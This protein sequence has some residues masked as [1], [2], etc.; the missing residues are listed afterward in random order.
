[1][2]KR[3]AL[4]FP[5]LFMLAACDPLAQIAA[6]VPADED[7]FA[8]RHV[9]LL[10]AKDFA[11]VEAMMSP[12]LRV[13][14]DRTTLAE[15]AALLPATASKDIQV[16]Y[17]GT[18]EI[19]GAR[20]ISMYYQYR[21]DE[22]WILVEMVLDRRADE[23]AVVGLHL[24]RGD[25]AWT[26]ANRFTLTGKGPQHF[27]IF[28]MAIFNPVFILFAVVQCVRTPMPRRK[29][30][31]IIFILV[32]LTEIQLNW[33]TGEIGFEPL[34]A[35]LLG[36]GFWKQ[37]PISPLLLTVGIPL[38]AIIFLLKRKKWLQPPPADAA[39]PS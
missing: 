11:A 35:L 38:G 7:E 5:V 25:Q 28:A 17:Y 4:I 1:M 34:K 3:L 26:E 33:T 21:F 9:A 13:A 20:R 14:A 2:L 36:A 12:E 31:W 27:V 37:S 23:L 24:Y 30:L 15:M 19:D 18:V 22:A 16:A 32:G 29:W 8:K 39:I 10:A 6:V